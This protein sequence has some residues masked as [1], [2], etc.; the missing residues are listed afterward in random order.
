KR[1]ENQAAVWEL[2][3]AQDRIAAE[4]AQA[5]AQAQSAAKRTGQAEREVKDALDSLAKHYEGFE[6]PQ[7]VG[8]VTVLLIRPQEVQAAIQA[9]AQAYS[10]Y[11]GAVADYDRA[12]F[13]LY[14]ALGNPAQYLADPACNQP[15]LLPD[16]PVPQ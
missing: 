12:Q 9:L 16:L 6:Q 11:Y 3:R 4:V 15:S 8:K 10:D 5:Y 1:A 13:R 7:T 2:F 14:R